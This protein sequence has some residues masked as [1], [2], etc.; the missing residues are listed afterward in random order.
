MTIFRIH[1]EGDAPGP[2]KNNLKEQYDGDDYA[3]TSLC[4]LDTQFAG[5][6]FKACVQN[7]NIM[8]V[9]GVVSIGVE[10]G[11]ASSVSLVKLFR[12]ESP[13]GQHGRYGERTDGGKSYETIKR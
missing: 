1:E 9:T 5:I 3:L 11:M 4:F 13:D 12:A 7:G 8:N 2:L 6:C 10:Q